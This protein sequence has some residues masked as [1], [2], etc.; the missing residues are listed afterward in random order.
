[1][2]LLRVTLL[3][4]FGPNVQG[5]VDNGDIDVSI[6]VNTRQ[7][8]SDDE[9]IAVGEFLDLNHVVITE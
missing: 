4:P 2:A 1:V 8:G 6:G 9:L 5:A 3:A 7:L